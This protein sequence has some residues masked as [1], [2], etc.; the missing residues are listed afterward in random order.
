MSQF[1][2]DSE[3]EDPIPALV[4]ALDQLLMVM[5]QHAKA[6]F[7]IYTAYLDAGFSEEQAFSITQSYIYH[8]LS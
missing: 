7:G 4:A 2:E 3:P 1:G 6:A 8:W 5:P